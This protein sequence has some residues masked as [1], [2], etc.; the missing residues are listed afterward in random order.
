[1]KI[2]QHSVVAIF[3][4]LAFLSFF[5]A[6]LVAA[7]LGNALDRIDFGNV[8]SEAV[9]QFAPGVAT[10]QPLAGTGAFNQTYREPYGNN[11]GTA[12]GSQVLVFTMG[13]DPNRQNY[14]SIRLWGN[15]ANANITLYN[16]P[17]QTT[18]TENSGGP[19]IS[20]NRFY[21]YTFPIPLSWTQGNKSVQLT[22]YFGGLAG[23][24][25]ARPVYSAYT[26][27]APCFVPDPTDPT[28]TAP[29]VTGQATL[30]ALTA[31][32]A[33]GTTATPGILLAYRQNVYHNTGTVSS[34]SDY[35]DQVLARQV[36]PGT[37][38]AP[39]ECIGLDLGNPVSTWG[40]AGK[41][42]DQWRDQV[43]GASHGPGYSSFPDELLS[44][45]Y[46]TYLL[47]PFTDANGNSVAG[48]DHYHDPTVLQH[49][50]NCLDGS[51]YEQ[52]VDGDYNNDANNDANGINGSGC[53]KGLCS[54]PRTTGHAWAGLTVREGAW[55]ISLEGVDTQA[56]GFAIINLL[57]D[58]AMP[59]STGT[60]SPSNFIDY[61]GGSFDANLNGGAVLRASSYEQM[62]SNQISY[63][64]GINGGTESQ[65]M[66]EELGLY[67]DYVALNK[68]QAL[69]PNS[70]FTSPTNGL[71]IAKQ[72][73]GLTPE[74]SLG[75]TYPGYYGGTG[76]TNYG[77]TTGGLGEAHGGL[78]CGFDGGGYGQILPWLATRFAQLAALDS[79]ASPSD[80]SALNTQANA[81]IN[82]FDQIISP[83]DDA[84][85]SN[86]TVTADTF[87]MAVE[88]FL[89]YRDTKNINANAGQFDLNAQF[90]ASDPNGVLHNAY[91]LRSAYL[92]TQYN[93]TPGTGASAGNGQPGG[94]LNYLRDLPS[95]EATVRSLIGVNPSTLTQL[96]AEPGA[97]DFAWADTRSGGVAFIN[98]GERFYMNA[99]WDNFE[100]NN[101]FT[102]LSQLARIHDT[103]SVIGERGAIIYLPY[104]TAN[105]QPDGNLS[106]T[107]Y[108]TPYVVRYG[109]YLVVM[110]NS[111]GAYSATLPAGYGQAEDLISKNYYN[112]GS[113]VS[114]AAGQSA[115]FWL[116]ASSTEPGGAGAPILATVAAASAPLVTGT[117]VNLDVLGAANNNDNESNLTYTWSLAGNS[118][119]PVAFSA[120]GTNAAKATTATF[121]VAGAYNFVVVIKDATNGLTISSTVTVNVNQT[122]TTL[123]VTP[124]AV[125]LLSGQTQ[126]YTNTAYDQF[127]EPL[128]TALTP[129]WSLASGVGS[130]NSLGVY[131]APTGLSGSA[132]VSASAGGLSATTTVTVLSSSL[133]IF[134]GSLD[135]GS[136]T[137]A[138]ST[139]YNSTSGV[140]TITAG[141][142]DIWNTSDQFHFTAVPLAG[143]GTITARVV[144]ETNTSSWAKAGVM[145]RNSLAANSAYA[146][147]FMSPTTANGV[148]YQAR[149]SAGAGAYGVSTTTGV[150]PPYW[151]RL[152]R[153]DNN[154][155]AFSSPD[156]V[157]WT[158]LGATQTIA[159]N[160]TIYV[161]LALSSVNAG[162]LNTS[163]FDN[164]SI[165]QPTHNIFPYDM[166]IGADAPGSYLESGSTVSITA[167]SGDI[168]NNSDSF[169]FAYMGIIGN[170]T[171]TA[172]V[173]S[174]SGP[175]TSPKVGVMIRDTLN[176]ASMEASTLLTPQTTIH[177]ARRTATGAGSSESYVGNIPVPYWLR[178]ARSGSTFTSSYS[179][180]GSTWT[181]IATTS[182]TP[183]GATVEAG[184]AVA[185]L[186][187]SASATAVFDNISVTGTVNA[188][189]TIATAAS[190]GTVSGS[191]VALNVL[192]ADDAGESN[193]T[194]TW[195]LL[196]EPSAPVGYSANGTNA[197]KNT[198]VTFAAGGTYYFQVT[199][200]DSAGLT[201]TSTVVQVSL[202][203]FPLT[204]VVGAGGNNLATLSWSGVLGAT[205]YNVKRS[206]NSG[207]G[208]VT[209]GS[210]SVPTF[211][212]TGVTNGTTY[213]YVVTAVNSAGESVASPQVSVVPSTLPV[214]TGIM[215]QANSSQVT[216]NWNGSANATSYNILRSTTSGGSYIILGSVTATTYTDTIPSPGT[217]Y[218][219]VIEATNNQITSSN[220]VEVEVI[221]GTVTNSGFTPYS[222]EII[223]NPSGVLGI[224]NSSGIYA[225]SVTRATG[226]TI[227]GGGGF[228][229]GGTANEL[230]NF[231]VN[232]SGS[233]NTNDNFGPLDLVT[234]PFFVKITPNSTHNQ[235]IT[236]DGLTRNPGTQLNFAHS[237]SFGLGVGT[238]TIAS[239][240]A[241]TANVVFTTAPTF[242]MTGGG[243]A[244][245]TTTVNILPFAFVNN[246]LATYDTTYGLRALNTAETTT[247]LTSGT[248]TTTNV[249][250]NATKTVS[251]ATTVNA[252]YI[253]TGGSITGAGPLTVTSG[254]IAADQTRTISVGTLAFGPAEGQ[255]NVANTRTLTVSS[256]I[257]GSAGLTVCLED[258]SATSANLVLGGANTYTGVTTIEGNNAAMLV[259]LTNGLALRDS[260]LDY[261]NYGASLQFGNGSTNVT[262]ATFG[263][264][265]GAQ[266]LAL[267]NSGTGGGALALTVGGDGDSTTYAGVLSGAGSVNK[268]GTG[269]LTLTGTNTYT[270]AT[271]V[272]NGTLRVNGSLAAGSAVAVN[273]GGTLGGTGTVNGPT[274]VAGTAILAPGSG[275]GV[276]GTLNFGAL[277]LKAGGV[278]NLDLATT[279]TSDKIAMTGAYTAPMNGTVTINLNALTGFGVGTY[280]LITGATGISAASFTLG[281]TPTGYTYTLTAASGT[282]SLVVSAPAAPTGLVATASD[283]Q[284]S[285]SWA[286]SSGATSFT[287]LR[288]NTSG[289]GYAPVMSGITVTSYSDTGLTD[290]ATYYY[291]V[292]ALNLGGT[293]ANS[294]EVK[295]TP[296]S[297]FQQW[298]AGNGLS[299]A[300]ADGA[301]PDGDGVPILLKYATGLT[302][303][304]MSV[305]G[306]ATISSTAANNLVLQFNRLSPAPVNYLVEASPDLAAWTT[307]ASLPAGATSWTTTASI[308]ETGTN[309]VS[310]TLTDSA[311]FTSSAQRFLRLRVT[312]A[313]DI[314]ILGTVPQG[315]VPINVAA[316]NSSNACATVD[317]LPVDRNL[318]QAVTAS[319]LTVPAANVSSSWGNAATPF[320]LR[321]LS[322]SGSGATFPITA[323]NGNVLTLA[324]QGVDL[325]SMTGMGVAVGDTYEILPQDTLAS[326]FGATGGS[327]LTG[328]GASSA[329]N[330]DL[331]IPTGVLTYFNNGT[332]WHQAGSLLNQNNVLLPPGSGWIIV[333]RG[334]TP[335]TFYLVG[336]VPEVA[337][338]LFTPPGGFALLSSPYPTPMTLAQTGFASASGWQSGPSPSVTDII[339]TYN[340]SGWLTYYYNGT[341]WRQAGSLLN[342]DSSSNPAGQIFY[343]S[344]QSSPS[345]NLS[346][347][348]QPLTYAP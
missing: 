277:T 27:T 223:L 314:S 310:V 24:Q 15:D 188:V 228:S 169:H 189:P 346:F 293:S 262:T 69:F 237:T 129:A 182:Y 97:A 341:H 71:A 172:R 153:N 143:N 98:H 9:H 61:L 336:R 292:Q 181:Q 99:N 287:V 110:N 339:E 17:S 101:G 176:P 72:V 102:G 307:I 37:A 280:N 210:P 7:P 288:S 164:V 193:L 279:T 59:A 298:L 300:T 34:P 63:L 286:A 90:L 316:S 247:T 245:G 104:N 127:G 312:T 283:G 258:Y 120:N 253:T 260:T 21:Y 263:G 40:G 82:G 243:G 108:F 289:S 133:G 6:Q 211:T 244:T 149:G 122:P 94:A 135:V 145:F 18:S 231:L 187:G 198:T 266:N 19:Y 140:Y 20:P 320:A 175:A 249:K 54:T 180:D 248:S 131:T 124:S 55:S 163:T 213:Y 87:I 226:V 192:G 159:M 246:Q 195:S 77:L 270:G 147:N 215:A 178:I 3:C 112:L 62:L 58:P 241:H 267:T 141:G 138:G 171:V 299:T 88:P 305:A 41:T 157:T 75:G 130:I 111:T 201:V 5:P 136:P 222:G 25:V 250:V 174:I 328:P 100:L 225:S 148:S 285:L 51:T 151:V 165:T 345:P 322:G 265:K 203:P 212:D 126:Q 219:Y 4:G 206:T 209:V 134:T 166:D 268:T 150:A 93:L 191:T 184:L 23:Q 68:L 146:I 282:L 308:V 304:T 26:H 144:S 105:E 32:R 173:V 65:N 297:P 60:T 301:V 273:A 240:T 317:N 76:L 12:T 121:T 218:Y 239:A 73:L 321:L 348:L 296:L 44:T 204:N 319:T 1:M 269:T 254:A 216:L 81:T 45:L 39:E 278:L 56:L 107:S 230:A 96:P 284:V 331:Y 10:G 161:G 106:G 33:V 114:I 251:S 22:F 116:A 70:T 197:A 158:Q 221:T 340:G 238:D 290:G 31:A 255:I 167:Q 29:T 311:A 235:L 162:S 57:N 323:V 13:C 85:V 257:T 227:S 202:A 236:F 274:T 220:S 252:I 154:F 186:N 139:S 160:N 217:T 52:A 233:G 91:A 48:L 36:L 208:Y 156:G 190:A 281:T 276:V 113:T 344:R 132:T 295:A 256:V 333:R 119:T 325:T 78:S 53:W 118:S 155:T 2:P 338:R 205:S 168:W 264:L 30:A 95:Y 66:F 329:D 89:S 337:L 115:I 229:T 49:I 177:F 8:S 335:L 318:I 330:V 275:S 80:Q 35:Y 179:P 28:G 117:S 142:S 83:V 343:V 347:V 309:P 200:T 50:V 214:P 137:L 103:S 332:N 86:G 196:G 16:A 342:Q 207:S 324:T 334:A 242:L 326:L 306:P 313:T 11:D 294:A 92:N 259:K 271:T 38:G 43:G 327:F 84:T 64:T 14:V 232:G 46:T 74:T 302:P 67:A 79:T 125:T 194:Y 128:Q 185:S 42:P 152:T 291:V 224:D 199:L 123:A 303:G 47:I 109:N 272:T 315:D 170:T 183:T 234:G 261:N